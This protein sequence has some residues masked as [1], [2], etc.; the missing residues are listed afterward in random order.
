MSKVDWKA[1]RPIWHL[2]RQDINGSPVQLTFSEGGDIPAPR[3]VRWAPD[4]KSILFLRAGQVHL[5]PA[6]GGE[7]R[8]LTRHATSALS[9]MWSPDG[10]A[11]YFLAS[12]P[13]TSDDRE[14][15]RQR[16]D[17]DAFE[18]NYKPQQLWK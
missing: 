12:D 13:P 10:D 8:A 4:G 15:E 5:I 11:V 2:W 18:E 17:V 6:D 14:R 1:G 16:D 7:P 3:S 9:P